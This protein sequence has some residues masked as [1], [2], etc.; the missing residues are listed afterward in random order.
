MMGFFLRKQLTTY[1]FPEKYLS[2]IFD[3]FL[4]TETVAQ[5]WF[6]KNWSY[7]F[8]KIHR[9]KPVIESLQEDTLAQVFFV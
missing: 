7:K 2:Q 1:F 3:M 9:K 6:L 4:Y 8:W 5:R